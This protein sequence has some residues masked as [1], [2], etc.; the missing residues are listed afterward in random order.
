MKD[1]GVIRIRQ[2]KKD[3]NLQA[4]IRGRKMDINKLCGTLLVYLLAGIEHII[5]RTYILPTSVAIISIHELQLC[6][7]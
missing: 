3:I 1:P 4:R 6:I 2:L 5:Y 7:Y